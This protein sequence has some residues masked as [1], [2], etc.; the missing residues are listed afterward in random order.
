M[1]AWGNTSSVPLPAGL[2]NVVAIAAGGSHCLALRTDGSVIAWGNDRLGQINLPAGLSGA[3]LAI[4]AGE[5]HSLALIQ[6]GGPSLT[7]LAATDVTATSAVLTASINP[8]G[9]PAAAA[10]Q[11]G[12]TTNYSLT[13]PTINL[14]PAILPRI[15]TYPLTS[16]APATTYHFTIEASNN[17][18]N[19]NGT[20]VAFTTPDIPRTI[21]G[22]ALVNHGEFQIQFA[23]SQTASYTVVA[24]TDPTLPVINWKVLGP[25]TQIAPGVFQFTDLQV[26]GNPLRFYSVRSP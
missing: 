12:A 3:A 25:C 17:Q 21:T 5:N 7:T 15:V 9:L 26:P 11:W 23:G 16:L 8:N 1:V 4:S 13:T 10:F 20:D 18:G 19:A 2:S 22:I 6:T 14:S 24:T